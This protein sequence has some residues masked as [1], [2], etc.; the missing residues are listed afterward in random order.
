MGSVSLALYCAIPS[1][2]NLREHWAARAKRAK[3]QRNAVLVAEIAAGRP[4]AALVRSAPYVAE[5]IVTLTRHGRRLDDDNLASAFKSIRDEVAKLLGLDDG[6]SRVAWVYKQGR[7]AAEGGSATIY[8]D[9]KRDTRRAS[10][11]VHI[12]Y[13][14]RRE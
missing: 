7:D 13:V 6:S 2:A 11:T 9:G 10:A 1:V 14:V 8:S 5:W 3:L 12:T 4:I